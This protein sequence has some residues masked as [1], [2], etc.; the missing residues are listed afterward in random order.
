MVNCVLVVHVQVQSF[1]HGSQIIHMLQLL[2]ACIHHQ[3]HQI[4]EQLEIPPHH[5][6]SFTTQVNKCSELL[7]WLVAIVNHI[8]HV[9]SQDKGRAIT[10]DGAKLLRV[11]QKPSKVNVE[12]VTILENL[13]GSAFGKNKVRHRNTG[14]KKKKNIPTNLGHHDVVIMAVAYTE[15]VGGHTITGT[16]YDGDTA[17]SISVGM[18]R[19]KSKDTCSSVLTEAVKMLRA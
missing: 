11:V 9:R 8:G 16:L 6:V 1:G 15:N 13:Y 4:E 7:G 10:V 14:K 19:K 2:D 5:V 3:D 17:K 18:R 12:E